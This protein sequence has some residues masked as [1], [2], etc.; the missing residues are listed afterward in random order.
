MSEENWIS[1]IRKE[2]GSTYA[3]WYRPNGIEG[4]A[5]ISRPISFDIIVSPKGIERKSDTGRTWITLMRES[6]NVF[7]KLFGL[8]DEDSAKK[9]EL[10]ISEIRKEMDD[11]FRE[12]TREMFDDSS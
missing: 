2:T 3:G 6:D 9:L 7:D 1:S 5:A 8:L 10:L 11:D 12:R 4:T